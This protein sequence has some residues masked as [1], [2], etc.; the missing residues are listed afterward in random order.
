MVSQPDKTWKKADLIEYAKTQGI[1]LTKDMKKEEIL[2]A[3]K[4]TPETELKSHPTPPEK[5]PQPR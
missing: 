3:I 1:A 4:K 2:K 5:K